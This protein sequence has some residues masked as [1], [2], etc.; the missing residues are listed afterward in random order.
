[1]AFSLMFWSGLFGY[2]SYYYLFKTWTGLGYLLRFFGSNE[3]V[4]SLLTAGRFGGERNQ[5]AGYFYEVWKE[6]PLFGRG[7]GVTPV[8]DSAFFQF[9]ATTGIIGL[10]LAVAV[11]FLL[12]FMSFKFL[13][14]N[15][16]KAESKLFFLITML[17]IGSS[18]GS[19][20]F[21][22]NRVSIV[23][24]VFLGLLHQ[25]YTIEKSELKLLHQEIKNKN[26]KITA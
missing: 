16:N 19:P 22:L 26:Y 14:Q 24:W 21:T 17:I 20:V 12:V 9:F 15:K 3:N 10:V 25:Y 13:K 7:F 4:I 8:Y 2:I 1:M 18:L 6:S 23:L 5:Q 11:L